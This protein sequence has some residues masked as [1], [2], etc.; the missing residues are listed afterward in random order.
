MTKRGYSEMGDNISNARGR[1]N[2]RCIWKRQNI[3]R[4]CWLTA[5]AHQLHTKPKMQRVCVCAHV[6]TGDNGCEMSSKLP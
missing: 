5:T 2:P 3:R 4:E 1:E 6:Y